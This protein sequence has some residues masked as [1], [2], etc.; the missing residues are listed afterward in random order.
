M[1]FRHSPPATI[2][3][4][5]L[6]ESCSVHSVQAKIHSLDKMSEHMFTPHPIIPRT[7]TWFYL[8]LFKFFITFLVWG[9]RERGREGEGGR[10][11]GRECEHATVH[12]GSQRPTCRSQFYPATMQGLRDGTQVT[13]ASQE[14]S[15]PTESYFAS[16][17]LVQTRFPKTWG[18][19]ESK[20][21]FLI[22]LQ[23]VC[24]LAA[25]FTDHP[26]CNL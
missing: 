11:R 2:Y 25:T 12:N 9:G 26:D 8:F 17:L 20:G 15:L 16:L 3:S 22:I 4:P 19:D 24:G 1:V 13:Q 7:G 5:T 23:F 10:E 18:N 6:S 21:C 14:V